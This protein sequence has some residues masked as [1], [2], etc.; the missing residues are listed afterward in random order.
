MVG[1]SG[2]SEAVLTS[3]SVRAEK[4]EGWGPGRVR[5]ASFIYSTLFH[6]PSETGAPRG[7]SERA[8]CL[9][10]QAFQG[11]LQKVGTPGALKGFL[12]PAVCP[13]VAEGE[14]AGVAA[15]IGSVCAC[16]QLSAAPQ[17]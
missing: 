10:A 7:C 11:L 1:Q 5:Q 14:S 8:L 17:S 3:S 9:C 15:G 16:R 2:A 6:G 12:S 4:Q 13:G